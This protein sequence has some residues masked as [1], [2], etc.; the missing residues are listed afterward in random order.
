M[1]CIDAYL[2]LLVKLH[3]VRIIFLVGG[4]EHFMFF[5]LLGMSSSRLTDIFQRGGPTTK[6][7]LLHHASQ[8]DRVSEESES[9]PT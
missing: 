9:R 1:V 5:H 6:Q 8:I 4:L 7:F 2:I 3:D